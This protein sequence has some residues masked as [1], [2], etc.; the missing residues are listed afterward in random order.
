MYVCKNGYG[1]RGY[2][3]PFLKNESFKRCLSYNVTEP[4]ITQLF[5]ACI[6]VCTYLCMYACMYVC[7]DH[8]CIHT[9]THTHTYKHIHTH[10][11]TSYLY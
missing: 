11:H 5:Y 8:T 3:S 7:F 2:Q 4:E 9:H 1:S 6:Y 10:T